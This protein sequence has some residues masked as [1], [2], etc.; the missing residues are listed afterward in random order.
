MSELIEQLAPHTLYNLTFTLKN[1]VWYNNKKLRRV[2][3][4][5]F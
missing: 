2:D 1:I 5:T 3:Y 4:S